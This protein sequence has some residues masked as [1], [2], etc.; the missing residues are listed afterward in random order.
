MRSTLH[1]MSRKKPANDA[2]V[3]VNPKWRMRGPDGD[4]G[5]L[6]SGNVSPE[7]ASRF[8]ELAD[9]ALGK[10]PGHAKKKRRD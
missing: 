4:R 7:H 6:P 8:L 2:E 10:K 3:W 1:V 9:I 5:F